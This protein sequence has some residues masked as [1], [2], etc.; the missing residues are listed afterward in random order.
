M[1][2]PRNAEITALIGKIVAGTKRRAKGKGG[3]RGTGRRQ[4]RS[5]A[6]DE[7]FIRGYFAR[8]PVEDLRGYDSGDLAG[9]ALSFLA[10]AS[11][12]KPGKPSLRL[13][14]PDARTHGWSGPHTVIEIVNDNMPFLVD[15]VVAALNGR[16]LGVRLVIHPAFKAWRDSRGVLKGLGPQAKPPAALREIA[17]S[18]IHVEIDRQVAEDEMADIRKTIESVLADVRVAV[19]DWMAMRGKI[20][21]VIRELGS[22]GVARESAEFVSEVHDFLKWLD[23]DHF[24]FLGYRRYDFTTRK[25]TRHARVV[26]DSGLGI[27]RDPNVRIFYADESTMPRD[28][29]EIVS[30]GYTISIS[31]ANRRS[32]VHRP[33]HMDTIGVRIVNA[34]GEVAG[35]HRFVGLFTSHAYSINPRYIP[36]LRRKISRAIAA[37]GFDA[38]SHDGKAFQHIL[39]TYPRDELFQISEDEL[40]E[41]ALGILH[42]QERQRTALFLRRDPFHR[43]VSCLV[44][45]PRERY[46]ANLRQR[47]GDILCRAFEGTV[48][49][50]YTQVG[51]EALARIHFIIRT[52]PEKKQGYDKDAIERD[53]VAASRSWADDL[54]DIL[55]AAHGEREGLAMYARYAP[56]CPASYRDTF[57]ASQGVHDAD[58]IEEVLATR[59]SALHLYRRQ[60]DDADELRLKIYQPGAPLPLS[61]ALPVLENMGLKVMEEIPFEIALRDAGSV[62]IH[63]FGLERRHA[64]PA[65]K[66]D[67]A[68][69]KELFEDCLARVQS[70]EVENDGFNQLVLTECLSWREVVVVR[71][72]SKYLRQARAPF[73]QDYMIETFI[74]NSGFAQ[75]LTA[76]FAAK[77]DPSD[78]KNAHGRIST[79]K[80]RYEEALEKVSILDEDRILRRFLNLVMASLRTNHYQ[81]DASGGHKPYLSIKLASSEIENLPLPRPWREIWVYSPRVEGIHLRGGRVARGGIRWSDRREDFR[82]E[83]LGLMKAQTVKNPVI[84]PVGAKGGFVVMRPPA[85]GGREALLAEGIECYRTLMRGLLDLT[86]NRVGDRVVIPRDIVRYDDDDPYLVVAADKGTATFSDIANGIARDYGFWLDDAF[87]SGGSVGYD[88]KKMG[89][90][91]RGAWESV[92]RHFREMGKDIQE[93]DFTCVG[94]GDMAGDVFG[95]GM[96]LSPHT[97]LVAAFN[98]MHIFLDPDPDPAKAIAERRR[99]FDTPRSTWADYNGKLISRGGGVFERSAKSIPISAE[100]KTLLGVTASSLPPDELIQ[101]ILRADVDLLWFGGIGTFVKATH[102]SHVEAGDRTNDALRVD[103]EDLRCK[104]VGEGANLGMTQAG[105][106]EYARAGGRLNTD[107]VD[108][109]AGVDCSDHEVNIKILLGQVVAAK[110][111][112]MKARDRLLA[113]MMEEVAALVL[114]DNY[115]QTGALSVAEADAA[116]RFPNYQRLIRALERAGRINRSVEG[117]PDEEGIAE[118]SKAG[119]GLTRPELAVLLAHAKLA[120]NDELLDSDLPDEH[121]L[122]DDLVDYFPTPLRRKY[123]KAIANHRLKREIIVTAVDNQIVN[124]AGP[125]FVNDLKERTGEGSPAIA[126]GFTIVRGAFGL[127][128]LWAGIESLDNKVPS[129]RQIDMQVDIKRLL[130]RAVMWFMR[131]G[132]HPLDIERNTD[133][134]RPGIKTLADGLPD[135]LSESGRRTLEERIA[136]SGADGVPESLARSVAGLSQMNSAL[137]IVC[138]SGHKAAAVANMARVYFGVGARFGFEWLRGAARRME[139]QTSWQRQA[140]QAMV[141]ELYALQQDLVSQ[142]V[143]SAGKSPAAD[144]AVSDWS[145]ARDRLVVRTDQ[146]LADIRAAGTTDLAMIAVALRQLRVLVSS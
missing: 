103:A 100:V 89:I 5:R 123:A 37:A 14:N 7:A 119:L 36:L 12:R 122:E 85:E 55:I 6:M 60:G 120:L 135:V 44:Y 138:L 24:T 87:A 40:V 108:N 2:R 104:V 19:T 70:G 110:T 1:V 38:S 97:R 64:L 81:K 66:Q 142:V 68:R 30:E 26:P 58:K 3:A 141:D 39:E 132:D 131:Y 52:D 18:Y 75:I 139:M 86:D 43:F 146:T 21:D 56:A 106:V 105:R 76:L 117:L 49:A 98:H 9:Q 125:T 93:E 101:H 102:E 13:F 25:D 84:V 8:V 57:S 143:R 78:R 109:S 67:F 95:N 140:V 10:F 144:D 47:F 27:L 41:N 88:H 17:E 50:A 94:I 82:T 46:S 74:R 73:S 130:E 51:D 83:I 72:Y 96:L 31:K 126:R 35:E 28:V 22:E 59:R 116:E 136:G 48:S 32:T 11:V 137:D 71:A 80:V 34:A 129:R 69:L 15:S 16:G 45:T 77:F 29:R 114:R 113:D 145:G 134:F 90:T 133:L 118:L 23:D 111:L 121:C 92:K 53:L 128:A 124:R 61:D 4:G 65:G 63:D 107:A 62:W 79:G 112:S 91:A 99:L 33:T 115:L 42:L 127:D 20:V 54:R